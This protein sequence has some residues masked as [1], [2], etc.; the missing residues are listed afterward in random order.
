MGVKRYPGQSV[1][2][3]LQAAMTLQDRQ[4]TR[5]DRWTRSL[6]PPRNTGTEPDNYRETALKIRI[7]ANFL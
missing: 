7:A 4:P 1:G 3:L 5:I 6:L 2:E